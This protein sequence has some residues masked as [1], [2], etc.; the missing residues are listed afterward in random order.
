MDKPTRTKVGDY[1]D[2]EIEKSR[3]EGSDED[4]TRSSTPS[5]SVEKVRCLATL[6]CATCLTISRSP[7]LLA[8]K[9]QNQI[10]MVN[11]SLVES[12][13]FRKLLPRASLSYKL[14]SI[15]SL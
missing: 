11:S 4:K 9:C 10:T 15:S 8:S 5:A 6:C 7:V 13:T 14:R 12:L 2:K 3:H 1:I